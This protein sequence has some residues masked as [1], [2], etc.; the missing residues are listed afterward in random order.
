[1]KRRQFIARSGLFIAAASVSDVLAADDE[2]VVKRI[3][4]DS[5]DRDL[6]RQ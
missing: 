6:I 5:Y 3:V 4:Q 1:M 2:A